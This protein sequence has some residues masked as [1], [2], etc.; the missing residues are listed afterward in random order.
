MQHS[1]EQMET[2]SCHCALFALKW[3]YQPH[4]GGA[5]LTFKDLQ[6]FLAV[7]EQKSIRRAAP[8][9]YISPQGLAKVIQNL[10]GKLNAPLFVRSRGV[11]EL[12]EYGERL[13]RFAVET[14]EEAELMRRD[15]QRLRLAKSGTIHLACSRMLAATPVIGLVEAFRSGHPEIPLEMVEGTDQDV[16]RLVDGSPPMLAL[17]VAPHNEAS[18]QLERVCRMP[19]VLMV[20]KTHPL[21]GLKE[22][23]IGD[24]AG[25]ELVLLE[26]SHMAYHNILAACRE[27]GAQPR[28]A[29]QASGASAALTLCRQG[30]GAAVV[31]GFLADT[32]N[33]GEVRLVPFAKGAP[34][35]DAAFLYRRDYTPDPQER[36]LMDYVCAQAK[37]L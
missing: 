36:R 2:K 16:H 28:I 5:A 18:Y 29:R 6:Y 7:C 34:T 4:M 10:E 8:L 3:C 31:M 33:L 24:L 32:L 23:A 17:T 9:A 12:T 13:R 35:W 30:S 25:Q 26:D 1:I 19:Y 11:Y 22:V 15:I 21:A 20:N 37:E 14:L 27:A